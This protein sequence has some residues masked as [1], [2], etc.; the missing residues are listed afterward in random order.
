ML[1]NH[2]RMVW[3]QV[4]D[5]RAGHNVTHPKAV[6]RAECTTE[7]R[8]AR[9]VIDGQL[10]L[11][12]REKGLEY[13]EEHGW[14]RHVRHLRVM[15]SVRCTKYHVVMIETV[16]FLRYKW[17]CVSAPNH[18]GLISSMLHEKN[19]TQNFGLFIYYCIVS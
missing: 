16:A 9:M 1:T 12:L 13:T 18:L 10:V 17:A 8:R 2:Q 6:R 15:Y 3:S 5:L 4:S 11:Y 19:A 7:T 14:V